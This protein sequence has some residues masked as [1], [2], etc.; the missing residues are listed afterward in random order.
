MLILPV[1]SCY[2]ILTPERDLEWTESGVE[3]AYRFIQKVWR[4]KDKLSDA[5][6]LSDTDDLSEA[7]KNC[8]R[9]THQSIKAIGNDIEKIRA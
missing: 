3:G 8:L 1:Y 9:I 2:L 6:A 7:A 4:L 5:P